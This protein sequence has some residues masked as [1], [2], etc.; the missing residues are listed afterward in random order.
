MFSVLNFSDDGCSSLHAMHR[1]AL[2]VKP[3][4]IDVPHVIRSRIDHDLPMGNQPS[5]AARLES[6]RKSALGDCPEEV[7][8][9][10][11]GFVEDLDPRV[12][13]KHGFCR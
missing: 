10:V 3:P 12:C 1:T 2:V 11:A 5:M 9:R 8:A 13:M 6:T 4:E 7:V